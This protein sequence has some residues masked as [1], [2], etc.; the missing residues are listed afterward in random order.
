MDKSRKNTKFVGYEDEV[1]RV[2]LEDLSQK[3]GVTVEEMSD[4]IMKRIDYKKLTRED[5][6]ARKYTF[7]AA[8]YED[9]KIMYRKFIVGTPYRDQA[10]ERAKRYIAEK[11]W[12]IPTSLNFYPRNYVKKARQLFESGDYI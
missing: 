10:R 8:N 3:Y 5:I 6:E 12:G 9:S 7:V 11:G 2:C 1:I 4:I